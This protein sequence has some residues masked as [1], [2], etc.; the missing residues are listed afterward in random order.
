MLHQNLNKLENRYK[1]NQLENVVMLKAY[2]YSK[3]LKK[4]HAASTAR[5]RKLVPKKQKRSSFS[6]SESSRDPTIPTLVDFCS[7]APVPGAS[8][9]GWSNGIE[10]ANT[11]SSPN[12]EP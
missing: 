12:S 3:T 2:V 8:S 5:R 10:N 6:F 1:I 9:L 11:D 4:R 7:E